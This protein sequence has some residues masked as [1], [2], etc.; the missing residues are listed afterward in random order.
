MQ[1]IDVA[2]QATRPPL[3]RLFDGANLNAGNVLRQG[4]A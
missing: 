1:E 3:H 2:L 4:S